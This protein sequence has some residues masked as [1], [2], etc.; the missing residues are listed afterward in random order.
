MSDTTFIDHITKIDAGWLNDVNDSIYLG[1]DITGINIINASNPT[2]GAVGNGT[3]DDTAAITTIIAAAIATSSDVYLP[4]IYNTTAS[5]PNFHSVRLYGPGGIKRSGVIWYAEPKQGIINTLNV[6]TTGNDSNDGL[7]SGQSF[8]TGQHAIDIMET[9]GPKAANGRWKILWGA[10]TFDDSIL[11]TDLPF[12]TNVLE[13]RGQR[14]NMVAW[15]QGQ[16][17]QVGDFRLMKSTMVFMAESE[18]VTGATEPFNP[19]GTS[20]DDTITWRWIGGHQSWVTGTVV[21]ATSFRMANTKVYYTIAGGTTGATAPSHTSTSAVSDGGVTW[22]F[23]G[24]YNAPP[25][26]YPTTILRGALN[27]SAWTTG[28]VVKAGASRGNGTHCYIAAAAG[29]CGVTAP[30]HT[31]GTVSD[32]AVPWRYIGEQNTALG[33]N[34]IWFN[35]A[36]R[37]NPLDLQF[38]NWERTQFGDYAFLCEHLGDVIGQFTVTRN[39]SIGL[40]VINSGSLIMSNCISVNCEQGAWGAYNSKLTLGTNSGTS[41]FVHN[42][43]SGIY[44]SRNC[45]AHTDWTTFGGN[46]NA[47]TISILSR[48]HSLGSNFVGN[49]KPWWAIGASEFVNNPDTVNGFYWLTA[50]ANT[51]PGRSD[52][53]SRVD[54]VHNEDCEAEI[55]YTAFFGTANFTASAGTAGVSTLVQQCPKFLPVDWFVH[56][57]RKLRV[58]VKGA[59]TGSAG[60]KALTIALSSNVAIQI[61]GLAAADTGNFVFEGELVSTGINT[62]IA[63]YRYVRSGSVPLVSN[64]VARTISVLDTNGKNVTLGMRVYS[65]L[66]VAGDSVDLYAVEWYIT[67]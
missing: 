26:T 18:G 19:Y 57:T 24:Q 65:T 50:A 59:W 31:T 46:R 42:C 43:D 5:I 60:A 64:N 49:T 2:Y 55:R 39:C 37:V 52:G 45:I 22:I 6:T 62:Q 66:A 29:T 13:L 9:I 14:A 40:A 35:P 8:A 3:A 34:G 38:I 12:F 67:G 10:G 41:C 1:K 15:A 33:Q 20:S 16:T 23:M 25:T 32:G 56:P 63:S 44:A 48:C 30:T 11:G 27:P 53:F 58:V 7:G 61:T 4:E 36:C 47:Q 17:V 51:E 54:D 21:P 28:Q